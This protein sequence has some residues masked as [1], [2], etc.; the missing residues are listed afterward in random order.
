MIPQK[1]VSSYEEIGKFMS[2][3]SDTLN[4][5]RNLIRYH[6]KHHF[7]FYSAQNV[8]FHDEFKNMERAETDFDLS[9]GQLHEEKCRLWYRKDVE[10]YGIYDMGEV[11]ETKLKFNKEYA[12]SVMK[13]K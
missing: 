6:I 11:S 8:A 1:L 13:T 5:Q 10:N 4:E 2:Q 12:F 7:K 3:W 9:R